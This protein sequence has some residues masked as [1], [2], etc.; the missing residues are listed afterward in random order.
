MDAD[1]E[2]RIKTLLKRYTKNNTLILNTHRMTMLDLVDR[3]I[4]LDKGRVVADGPKHEV[5]SQLAKL[6][7]QTRKVAGAH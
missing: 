5:M 7:Q 4:L 3:V 2:G 6:N 1:Q